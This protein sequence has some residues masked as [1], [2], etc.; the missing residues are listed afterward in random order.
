MNG[1]IDLT[2]LTE[3]DG[4]LSGNQDGRAALCHYL[5]HSNRPPTVSEEEYKELRNYAPLG[6]LRES[7]QS[8]LGEEVLDVPYPAPK[9]PKFKFIDLFAGIGGFRIAFQNA[10]GECVFTSE[11]DRFA[12]QT[13]ERNFGDVPYGD[14]T[15]I[16]EREIPDHDVLCAGFPCQP[17]SLAG[18]SKK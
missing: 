13:Y 1:E 16:D 4:L 2:N 15:K 17:F 18:V 14:I 9:K 11:W 6:I 12:K 3:K 7:W 5:K 8:Y 10:G